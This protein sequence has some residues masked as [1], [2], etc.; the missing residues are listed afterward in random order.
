M[1]FA[2]V[3]IE[4]FIPEEFIDNLRFELNAIGALTIDGKYDNCMSVSKV[5]GSWRALEGADPFLG[6]VGEL[7]EA[8]EMKVE[9]VCRF[10]LYKAAVE[11]IKAVHPYETPVINVLPMLII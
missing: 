10:E 8:Y 2:T 6:K 5:M 1:T 9:F 4:T 3:K 11:I 7:C